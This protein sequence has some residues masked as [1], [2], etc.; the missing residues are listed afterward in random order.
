MRKSTR[1]LLILA[2]AVVALGA[3]VYMEL[4][5]ERGLVPQPLTSLDPAAVTH[6][7][8]RCQSCTARVFERVDGAWQM[9]VPHD[10]A[11]NPDAVNRL[12][13]VLRAPVRTGAKMADY[14]AA[15]LGLDPPQITVIADVTRIDIGGEDPIDHDRYVRIGDEL[16]RV[17]DRFSARLMESPDSELIDPKAVK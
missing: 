16:L 6:L 17:P 2:V 4:V 7:E 12:L 5:R 3:A 14:D 8:I 11:A 10:A 15:K 1:S 9:R 13:A